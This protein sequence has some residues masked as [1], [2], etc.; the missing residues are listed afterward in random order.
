M[1]KDSSIGSKKNVFSGALKYRKSVWQINEFKNRLSNR[2]IK[3]LLI[4]LVEYH[5]TLTKF[6]I[7]ETNS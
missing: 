7:Q 5:I 1:Q 3:K 6:S 2:I 4:L